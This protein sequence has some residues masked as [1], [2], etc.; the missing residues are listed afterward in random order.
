MAHNHPGESFRPTKA[1]KIAMA[2][3]SIAFLAYAG[4]HLLESE[5]PELIKLQKVAR[6]IGHTAFATVL[7]A[8]TVSIAQYAK[9]AF[10][11]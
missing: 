6:G 5:Q 3:E 8:G 9:R 4:A 10:E 2:A 1:G 11:K 7:T